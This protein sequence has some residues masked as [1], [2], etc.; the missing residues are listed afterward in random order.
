MVPVEDP[1]SGTATVLH[2]QPERTPDQ[3][4]DQITDIEHYRDHEQRNFA[5]L[6]EVIQ[7]SNP[8]NQQAPKDKYFIGG[9]CCGYYVT[10]QCLIVDFFPY[11]F[12]TAGKKLLGSQRDFVFDRDDLE[13]HVRH[14]NDPQKVKRGKRFEKVHP[15]QH[16]ERIP[17]VYTQENTYNKN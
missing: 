4:T 9:L 17:P 12:E 13:K 1:A 14:P 16:S 2:D 15:I 3:D 11:R 6:V 5:D 7:Y 8:C 10:P